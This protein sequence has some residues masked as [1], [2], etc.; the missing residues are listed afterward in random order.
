MEVLFS[1]DKI[2]QLIKSWLTEKTNLTHIDAHENLINLGVHSIDIMALVS[3]LRREG[4]RIKFSQLIEKPTFSQWMLLV[5]NSKFK[6]KKSTVHH[7]IEAVDNY[8]PFPLTDVQSAYFIGRE[9]DQVLGG[10]GCHAYFEIIGHQ[11]D[12]EKLNQAWNELQRIHPMLRCRFIDNHQQQFLKEPIKKRIDIIELDN[13][14]ETQLSVELAKYRTELSHKKLDVY[15]GEVASLTAFIL[16]QQKVQISLNIDL[17]VADV[18][19]ISMIIKQLA[20]LYHGHTVSEEQITFKTYLEQKQ[21]D[22]EQVEQDKTFWSHKI[23]ELQLNPIQLPILKKPELVEQVKVSRHKRIIENKVWEKIK[24]NAKRFDTTPSIVLLTCYM[25]TLEKWSNQEGFY[26]NI[27]LF[28]RES[29]TKDVTHIVADFTNLLLVEHI[30]H[31]NERFANTLQ[32]VKQT[33]IENVSH[34]DYSGV[35]VQRDVSKK[36]GESIN[37]APVVF[38]CNIDYELEND[39]TRQTFGEI[40]YMVSQTPGVWLDFQSYL[41]KGDLHL[42]WDKVDDLLTDTTVDAMLDDYRRLL[43]SLTDV[44]NWNKTNDILSEYVE[45]IQLSDLKQPNAMLYEGFVRNYQQTPDNIA[46]IA[47]DD[48]KRMTYGELFDKAMSVKQMLEDIGVKPHDYVGITLPRGIDQVV[49]ILGVLFAGAAYV[50]IGIQQPS[51]R[52]D[53]IYKQVGIDV[54]ISNTKYIES[55]SLRSSHKKMIDVNLTTKPKDCK[56]KSVSANSSAYVI[57]TSGSTGVPKGVEITHNNAM[58]TI[59]DINCKYHITNEDTLLMVSSIDFDLSVYDIFGILDAGGTL[60][61]TTEENFKDANKWLEI[62]HK[63]NVTVW[64]SVP[65]LFD[66]L[67]TMAEGKNEHLPLS[68]VLLSGDWIDLNLPQRFYERSMSDSLV[69][70]MGGATEASIWSNHIDVPHQLPIDWISIPYGT[71]LKGQMYKVVDKFDRVCPNNVVGE[72]HIGGLGVAKGYI[73][74]QQLTEEKFYYDNN[75]VKWYRTGDQGRIWNDGTIEFLGRID[76]QVKIKGHRIEIGEIEKAISNAIDISKVKVIKTNNALSAF[77]IPKSHTTILNDE[78]GIKDIPQTLSRMNNMIYHVLMKM[79]ENLNA[80]DSLNYRSFETILTTLNVHK[81]YESIV[82]KWLNR[83]IAKGYINEQDGKYKRTSKVDNAYQYPD[84]NKSIIKF[85]NKLEKYLPKLITGEL[86]PIELFYQQEPELAPSKLAELMPWNMAIQDY[87]FKTI[88]ELNNQSI[89]VLEFETRNSALSS[90]LVHQ[91]NHKGKDYHYLDESKLLNREYIDHDIGIE[92]KNDFEQLKD[93]HYD[94]II[95]VNALHRS[96]NIQQQLMKLKSKLKPDGHIIIVEPNLSLFIEQITVDILNAYIGDYKGKLT[97]RDWQNMFTENNF[98]CQ[99]IQQVGNDRVY[100]NIYCISPT[101]ITSEYI[102]SQLTH[103][104]PNY[105][106]PAH[107]YFLNVFPLNKNGKIDQKKLS[108]L[109]RKQ[110]NSDSSVKA[111]NLTHMEQKILNIWRAEFNDS[112]INSDSNFY[113]I[114]GDSLIATHIAKEIETAFHIN[115]TIKDAMENTTIKA[116][117][118]QVEKNK[119]QAHTDETIEFQTNPAKENK[120]FSLTDVQYSYFIGRK[121]ELSHHNVSTHCYFEINA[122]NIELERLERAWNKLIH[123]HGMMRAIITDDGLQQILSEVPYYKFK[124]NHLENKN[125]QQQQSSLLEIRNRLSHQVLDINQWPI[126]NIEVSILS[127]REVRLHISFDNLIFDGWSM[128]TLLSQ[129]NQLYLNKDISQQLTALNFRDYVC[130][131]N[132]L[133]QTEQYTKDRDYWLKRVG[134]FLTAPEIPTMAVSNDDANQFTRRTYHVDKQSW[135]K[136]KEIAKGIELTPTSLLIGIYAEAI[137]KVSHNDNFSLN[138]TQFNRLPVHPNIEHVIGDFTTLT[139]LE[140]KH[141]GSTTLLDR[142]KYVQKQLVKDLE[143]HLYSGVE[144]QRDLR[145]YCE[146]NDYILMPFV[147]TSGLG[148]HALNS[149]NLLGEIVY[150]ISQTPQ[151]WLDNQ[152]IERDG[153]LDIYW[154]SVDHRIG[155]DNL[156]KMFDYFIKMIL[157]IAHNK[158]VLNHELNE[159]DRYEDTYFTK[160]DSVLENDNQLE[161]SSF[162]DDVKDILTDIVKQEVSNSNSRF[163]EIGGDSLKA[164]ELTNKI[165]NQFNVELELS[166]IFTNPTVADIAAKIEG[167]QHINR[168]EG[169]L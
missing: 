54:I 30:P 8:Q 91:I 50:P 64:D 165:R 100:A 120:S 152:V 108:Q 144:F 101:D 61:L 140:I 147:F 116:Q 32:R 114:G 169:V 11:V 99:R 132:Q 168:D 139:L 15:R 117:A 34:S 158:N 36:Y 112:T 59:L 37:I 109:A 160:I 45:D 17:L 31:K 149:Q 146:I 145:K 138:I 143:H 77:I 18:L 136:L 56:I 51:D 70:A 107:I 12:I 53:K 80:L 3:K 26:V 23:D 127:D 86:N 63:Y 68:K 4:L 128:F 93:H 73:G 84:E 119:N 118:A 90:D 27:P 24:E 49:S 123:S 97:R 124:T 103:V 164:I 2:K 156:D 126:F 110:R 46:L 106:I 163:F 148:I 157:E 20:H 21:I 14:D 72:L 111:D 105:M 7:S 94:V 47:S 74:D 69:V 16:P 85:L 48:G 159:S 98:D 65:I 60:I 41:V 167:S 40:S 38:A 29:D 113:N 55:C 137:R 133:K 75:H 162:I 35:Q 83:L 9:Q 102:T 57:M 76:N 150:N 6:K 81:K 92:V 95:A 115:F 87:L 44:D 25:L 96:F 155:T 89:N 130:Y 39:E 129:W 142:F 161:V 1:K 42:C 135:Q 58:N 67:V 121:K 131:L 13:L 52:R 122:T 82:N 153:G 79:F 33:F 10:V 125:S 166:F 28:N 78:N 22:D 88:Q 104:I 151:V 71:A 154:D 134:H 66:M 5:D 19:S 62:I 43:A 141:Y